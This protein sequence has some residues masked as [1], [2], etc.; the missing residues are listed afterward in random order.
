MANAIFHRDLDGVSEPAPRPPQHCHEERP[1]DCWPNWSGEV[2]DPAVIEAIVRENAPA[3]VFG[4]VV[5]LLGMTFIVITFIDLSL[6]AFH[7]H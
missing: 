6:K 2:E 7:L 3:I 1:S 4:D 5:R